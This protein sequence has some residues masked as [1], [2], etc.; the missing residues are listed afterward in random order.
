MEE[1]PAPLTG[2][3]ELPRRSSP[4]EWL[5]SLQNAHDHHDDK[6]REGEQGDGS[7]TASQK[8]GCIQ[9][10]PT[11]L[12]DVK[13]NTK[14]YDPMMVSIGP[15]HYGKPHLQAGETLKKRL[16]SHFLLGRETRE[17]E[18][19]YAELEEMVSEARNRYERDSTDKFNDYAFA[20]LMFIDA[21]FILQFV[22]SCLDGRLS[23]LKIQSRD[24]GFIRRDLLL[25]ENQLPLMVVDKLMDWKPFL[26]NYLINYFIVKYI[27]VP[28]LGRE[29][30]VIIHR[31]L[32]AELPLHLL[33]L[34]HIRLVG[35]EGGQ[36][37]GYHT[38]MSNWYRYRSAK[39]LE[40]A[41]IHIRPS[42]TLHLTDVRFQSI[43]LSAKLGLPPIAINSQTKTILLNLA[44]YETCYNVEDSWVTSY[45]C[46]MDSLIDDVE[47]VT[48]LG[49]NGVFHNLLGTNQQV[50]DLFN[51]MANS[52]VPNPKIY[53]HAKVCIERHFE[54]K[55]Q[56]WMRE[57][58]RSNF[59]FLAF[60][61]AIVSIFLSCLQTY[62][63]I[64]PRK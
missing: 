42:K 60:A 8:T 41:G 36:E 53:S 29:Q 25:M 18:S 22:D 14:C 40:S 3:R 10:V 48:E 2:M 52:L 9:R 27:E 47:D 20:Q 56:I 37:V 11:M 19:I 62:Y 43:R 55:A 1:Q 28:I 44:A 5:I 15:I 12:R 33:H 24:E 21:C 46:F 50:A 13:A 34:V 26:R 38:A 17:I 35:P 23:E 39:K 7:I 49:S 16:A 45:I 4:H 30:M 57:W 31:D 54:N 32:Y 58:L 64:F 6:E 63:T 61:G 51:D 59:T